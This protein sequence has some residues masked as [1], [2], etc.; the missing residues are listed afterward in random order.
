[1]TNVADWKPEIRRRLQSLQLEPT[2]NAAIVEELSQLLDD[3]YEES[4]AGGA[5]EA[6]AYQRTLAELSGS[7]LLARELRRMERQS[8]PEPLVL[9]ANRRTNMIANLWRDLRFGLRMLRKSPGFTV[10]AALTL[11]L[12][13]GANT[14]IYSVVNGVLLRPLPYPEPERLV[15]VWERYAALNIEQ[16]DPAAANYA[17]WK[18]QSQ[19]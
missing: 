10:V 19:S 5:T 15:T 13:I 16:N 14:A 12:G 11:A 18:A 3:C 6:E 17:D 4:L 7:E 8:K 9:G 1:M 2:R